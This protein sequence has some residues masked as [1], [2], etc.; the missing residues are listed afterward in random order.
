MKLDVLIIGA[1]QAGLAMAYYLKKENVSFLLLDQSERV[2]DSWRKRYD[3]LVLFTS[4]QYSGLP[5]LTYEG[6]VND[7]PTKDEVADYL[8]R[9]AHTFDF[10]IQLNTTVHK[11]SKPTNEFII[12][13]NR[14]TF[15]AKKVI[16]ASG[17]FQQPFIPAF[18]SQLSSDVVQLHSSEYQNPKGLKAG[19]VL[20]VGGGNS[21]T[22]IATELS[23]THETY[24]SVGHPIKHLPLTLF[25]KNIFWFFDQLGIYRFHSSSFLGKKLKKRPDPIFGFELKEKI[26]EK[27]LYV[28]P[29]LQ[30]ITDNQCLFS[31]DTSLTID[32]IIWATGFLPF[33]EWI[34]IPDAIDSQGKPLHQDGVSPVEGL[35][36]IG[37]PWQRNRGSALLLGAGEDAKYLVKQIV[38]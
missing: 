29:R 17:A 1:G 32:N 35:F 31:D 19:S 22:Q 34:T 2:G 30:T 24:L 20:V 15:C 33:Y 3:S 37:M 11:L 36:Y 25:G 27:Q 14:N 6:N 12:E 8:E 5:G 9:Y 13:T 18:S 23:D 10:P 21:G 7:V 16:V 26:K 28:K 4:K 38:Q